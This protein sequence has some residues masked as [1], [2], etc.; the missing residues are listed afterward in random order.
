[1]TP[2]QKSKLIVKQIINDF[3]GRKG[4]RQGWDEIDDD[5][6]SEIIEQW[7]SITLKILQQE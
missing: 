4:L 3:T 5:I 6:Q 2:E 7:E 1:M